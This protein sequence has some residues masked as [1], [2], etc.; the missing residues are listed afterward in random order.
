MR[1]SARRRADEIGVIFAAGSRRRVTVQEANADPG[2][3]ARA[4]LPLVGGLLD[5]ELSEV[6]RIAGEVGLQAAQPARPVP[7]GPPAPALRRAPGTSEDS[8]QPRPGAAR[9]LSRRPAAGSG[10]SV[11]WS[12]AAR[13]APCMAASCS[14]PA[15]SRPRLAAPSPRPGRP[16]GRRASASG[17]RRIQGWR[18]HPRFRA[19]PPGVLPDEQ[20]RR[21]S[22]IDGRAAGRPGGSAR[23]GA[24]SSG[25]ADSPRWTSWRPR[26]CRPRRAA[27]RDE[28]A[29]LLTTYAG[30]PTPLFRADRL[31]R[32]WAS[33]R[34]STSSARTCSTPERTS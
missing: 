4:G 3:A 33:R 18:A 8:L 15:A 27:Y 22:R 11:A 30:R 24:G 9:I 10:K 34:A 14:S 13:P 2:R 12:L 21:C 7:T 1:S 32:R 31:A 20:M 5:A 25:D 16:S 23:T 29:N 6:V 17:R 28:L 26:D 19:A